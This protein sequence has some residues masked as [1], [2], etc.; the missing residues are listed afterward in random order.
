MFKDLRTFVFCW[1]LFSF[2]CISPFIPNCIHSTIVHYVMFFSRKICNVT[3]NVHGN[4]NILYENNIFMANHYEGIDYFVLFPLI[5]R[6]FDVM[7][8]IIGKHDMLGKP[9]PLHE[10]KTLMESF[11]KTAY[12]SNCTIPYKRGN[13]ESGI[14]VRKKVVEL[15]CENKK[16]L[17][18]PEGRS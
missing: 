5:S 8:Y 6:P 9:Y 11:I 1:S 2:I 12:K 15:L 14:H 3:V 10:P 17:L 4:K 16:I 13:K 7:T 18:F